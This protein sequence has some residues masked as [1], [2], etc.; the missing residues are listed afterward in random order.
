ME[1]PQPWIAFI[2]ISYIKDG[3]TGKKFGYFIEQNISTISIIEAYS[4]TEVQDFRNLKKI[5]R[6]RAANVSLITTHCISLQQ[7]HPAISE[8]PQSLTP[9]CILLRGGSVCGVL[10]VRVNIIPK[11]IA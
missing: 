1:K 4:E 9:L 7:F 10:V 5:I 2:H 8:C 3:I 6:I 11:I